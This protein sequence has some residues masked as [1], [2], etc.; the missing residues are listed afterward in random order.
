[1]REGGV[2]RG[3]AARL[4]AEAT[5]Y[6]ERRVNEAEGDAAR[7][8]SLAAEYA[9]ARETTEARLFL[10]AMEEV[11]PRLKKIVVEPG[12]VDLDLVQRK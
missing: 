4:I 2:G 10:E 11:L 7:F 12:G 8:T 6:C 1:M 3:E 5:G 9:K